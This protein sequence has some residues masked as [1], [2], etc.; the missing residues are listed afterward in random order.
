MWFIVI[1]VLPLVAL[2]GIASATT[3]LV[4]R[5]SWPRM[6]AVVQGLIVVGTSAGLAAYAASED[7]YRNDGTLRWDAY[8]AKEL[9]AAAVAAGVAAVVGLVTARVRDD[10]RLAAASFVGSTIAVALQ[11]LAFLANSLN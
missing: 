9:T 11:F 7:D 1:W 10:Y 4:R 6:A 8:D 3:A 5:A 2:G